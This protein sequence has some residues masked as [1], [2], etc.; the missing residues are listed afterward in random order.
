MDPSFCIIA[1][2]E[3]AKFSEFIGSASN[4]EKLACLCRFRGFDFWILFDFFFFCTLWEIYSFHILEDRS[5][6]RKNWNIFSIKWFSVGLRKESEFNFV[7]VLH[8]DIL[9][10]ESQSAFG[11]SWAGNGG[12]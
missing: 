7:L 12:W 1:F 10:A 4:M 5:K 3:F 8:D 6:L 11:G 2:V 9:S